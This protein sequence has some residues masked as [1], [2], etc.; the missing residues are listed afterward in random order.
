MT[1]DQDNQITFVLTSCGR[2]DLLEETLTSFLNYNTAPIHRYLIIEDSGDDAVRRVTEKMPVPIDVI[3]NKPK[4]GHMASLDRVYPEI[5][6]PLAFHCEDDWVFYRTGFIE[7]SMIV[8]DQDPSV[9]VVACRCLLA[10]ESYKVIREQ[11]PVTIGGVEVRFA[12]ARRSRIWDGYTLNP[13]L[14][15]MSDYRQMGS[16][17]QWGLESD[18][19]L[20]FKRKGMRIA[21]LKEPACDTI[22]R[23]R[24]LPKQGTVRQFRSLVTRAWSMWHYHLVLPARMIW[25]KL[26]A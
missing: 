15:R 23:Q 26:K 13:G 8:L 22:G 4:L 6:T 3:V 19:S 16:F 25:S 11:P 18:A 2:F 17:Q 21:F 1:E 9:S 7:E 10:K 24:S 20:F 12:P 14:R 5:K